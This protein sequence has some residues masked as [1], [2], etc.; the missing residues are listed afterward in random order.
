[1]PAADIDCS[2]AYTVGML[3]SRWDDVILEQDNTSPQQGILLM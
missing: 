1:L 3:A 2:H